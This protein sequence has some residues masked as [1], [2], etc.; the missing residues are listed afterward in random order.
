[1]KFQQIQD[2]WGWSLENLGD[3]GVNIADKDNLQMN[4]IVIPTSHEHLNNMDL[5]EYEHLN[6]MDNDDGYDE[7]KTKAEPT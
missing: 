7:D 3:D 1:M 5:H 4:D 2:A 6:Y